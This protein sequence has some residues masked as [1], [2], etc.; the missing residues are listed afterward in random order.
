MPHIGLRGSFY[1]LVVCLCLGASV[2]AWRSRRPRTASLSAGLG[3]VLTVAGLMTGEGWR[4]VLSSGVFRMRGTYA[5]PE[6]MDKRRKHIKI[7]F[8]EDAADATVSVEQGDGK[9]APIDIG[10]RIN[11][12]VDASSR[13]D[14]STQYL[15][16]HLPM[17]MRPDAKSAF[18]LGVGSGVS[19]GALLGHPLQKIVIA[20]NCEPVLRAARF[21]SP[22]NRDVLSNPRVQ[23]RNEDA[24]TVLKLNSHRYDVIICEPS[25]PWMV[26]VGSVFSREFYELASTRLDDS[27]VICQWFHVYEMSD[28]IIG[29]VLRTFASVFAHVEIWDPGSGDILMLGAKR[30]FKSSAEVYRALFDR[31]EARKDME[32]IGIKTPE[33]FWARQL[34]SQRTAFAIAGEGPIQSD[35]F[36]VLEYEAPKAFYIGA[37]SE[38]LTLFD[39]RTW[40]W[41]LAAEEKAKALAPLDAAALHEVFGRF[42]S[43]NDQ[44]TRCLVMGLEAAANQ[45]RPNN[46][47]IPCIFQLLVS[48][49]AKVTPPQNASDDWKQLLEAEAALQTNPAAFLAPV[50]TIHRILT[51]GTFDRAVK[52]AGKSPM[53]LAALGAKVSWRHGDRERAA[54][55]VMAGLKIDPQSAELSYI[56][57]ILERELAK[58]PPDAP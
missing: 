21:F 30:P 17:A 53:D 48:S 23:V 33:A 26:G 16:A 40:Q 44:L 51:A 6:A 41:Q 20:E 29:L 12:K 55:L 8:Y 35:I 7:L 24:R 42:S 32:A 43:V 9:L 15:C 34:A 49:P 37:T 28:G 56:R 38:L 3:V 13:V 39:E 52:V 2:I 19:A 5:D 54:S 36:P 10:L 57:R 31:A 27:G 1:V 14:L 47:G 25:N 11:G 4:H 50:T 58:A 46:A 22:L 45:G 18:I